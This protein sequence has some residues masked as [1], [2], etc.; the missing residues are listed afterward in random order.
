MERLKRILKGI[1]LQSMITAVA[2]IVVGLLFI[3]FPTNAMRI[4]C[5]ISGSA[6][7][8]WGVVSALT[9]LF[10][11]E[12][13][14]GSSL[15]GGIALVAFG[16]LLLVRPDFVAGVLTVI[17]GILLIVD[18]VL[19]IQR[20]TEMSRLKIKGWW[21]ALAVAVVTL[22]L[23]FLVVFD[24]FGASRTLMIFAGV[25]LLFDG[26]CDVVTLIYYSIKVDKLRV[27]AQKNIT[28][29]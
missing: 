6:M 1:R 4:I 24:P 8:V 27:R 21:L 7:L 12:E 22:V 2:L 19:K 17:F 15:V 9:Y 16:I 13:K 14:N 28:D 25:S 23:G 18:S 3:I 11:G 5:Y 29:I 10:G 26:V 20:A